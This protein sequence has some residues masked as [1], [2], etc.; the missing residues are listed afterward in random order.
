VIID[1]NGTVKEKR[2]IEGLKGRSFVFSTG[3]DTVYY[4]TGGGDIS[5]AGSLKAAN[6]NGDEFWS[7]DFATHNLGTPLIDNS[8]NIYVFG[9]DSVFF[10]NFFLYCI[11]GDGSMKWKYRIDYYEYYSSPTIDNN[12]NIVFHAVENTPPQ[13]ENLIVS[14]DYNGNENWKTTLPGDFFSNIINHGLVCDAEGKIYFGPTFGG[15]FYCLNSDGTILWTYNLGELEY[16]SSPAIGSDG[17]LYIG[18]HNGFPIENLIAIRDTVTFVEDESKDITDYEL[19]QN[20]PNPFNSTTNIRYRIAESERVT[21]TVYDI[22][23]RVVA[24]ILDRYQEA[25]SYDVIFQPVDLASGIY[26]YTLISGNFTTTKKLILL[27]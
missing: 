7:Y 9:T 25:G 26:F 6:L 2:T 12:G 16:D 19:V 13:G 17:T 8:N 14:L 15:N 1:S 18:T 23:G 10:E 5:N 20:F 3:G 24:V 21:L 22:V 4:F 27:K 11:K